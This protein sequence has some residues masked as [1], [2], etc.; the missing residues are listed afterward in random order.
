MSVSLRDFGWLVRT[1]S[2]VTLIGILQI[3]R[4]NIIGKEIYPTIMTEAGMKTDSR[5]YFL[6]RGEAVPDW[7]CEKAR[8]RF[9]T[10]ALGPS[11]TLVGTILS[12]FADLINKS[13][14]C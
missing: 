8:S 9:A 14:E 1:G 6:S 10:G 11:T 3:A 7:V 2:L 4:P 5:E 13:F 12:G